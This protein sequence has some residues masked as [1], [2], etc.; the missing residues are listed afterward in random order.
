MRL[1]ANV[2]GKVV[3]VCG[4]ARSGIS[5]FGDGLAPAELKFCMGDR[6]RRLGA[7]PARAE[8]NRM[9]APARKPLDA[10][11]HRITT[12]TMSIM[13]ER[14]SVPARHIAFW[15][16]SA[17]RRVRDPDARNRCPAP[18]VGRRQNER[19]PMQP[20]P[21]L[22]TGVPRISPIPKPAPPKIPRDLNSW[23]QRRICIAL[24]TFHFRSPP[25]ASESPRDWGLAPVGA[26]PTSK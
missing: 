19:G 2:G 8:K 9:E 1:D 22:P 5:G 13:Y 23:P 11:H 21:R 17:G 3:E 10:P 4:V 26:L 6:R 14:K 15:C 16:N 18:R 7:A 24:P 20:R 25:L 12:F